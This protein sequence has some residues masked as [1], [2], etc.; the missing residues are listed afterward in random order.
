V[1][2]SQRRDTAYRVVRVIDHGQDQDQDLGDK[3]VDRDKT[4]GRDTLTLSRMLALY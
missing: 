1:D 2:L 3:M 4:A